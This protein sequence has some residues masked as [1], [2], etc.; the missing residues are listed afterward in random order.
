MGWKSKSA[1]SRCFNENEHKLVA[2][3]KMEF[4]YK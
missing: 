1:I 4:V 2:E 3:S